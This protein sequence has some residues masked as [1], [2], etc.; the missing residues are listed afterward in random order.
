MLDLHNYPLF[1]SKVNVKSVQFI[2]LYWP[3]LALA[4]EN[5]KILLPKQKHF[6][7]VIISLTYLKQLFIL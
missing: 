7:L 6:A 4:E 2:F 1:L 5:I 3:L